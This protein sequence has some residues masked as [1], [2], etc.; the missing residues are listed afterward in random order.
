MMG[1]P[2][3]NKSA[4]KRPRKSDNKY[5]TTWDLRGVR[6]SGSAQSR[7]HSQN[8]IGLFKLFLNQGR[9]TPRPL[10]CSVCARRSRLQLFRIAFSGPDPPAAQPSTVSA[11][12]SKNLADLNM[13]LKLEIGNLRSE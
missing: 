6:H 5:A 10:H 1:K 13:K 4:P 8:M 2:M 9:Q 12:M 7:S 11:D 3:Q